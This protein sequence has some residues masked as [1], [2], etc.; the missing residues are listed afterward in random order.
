[1]F[2]VLVVLWKGSLPPPAP[3]LMGK[4]M[5]RIL[6]P[7]LKVDLSSLRLLSHPRGEVLLQTKAVF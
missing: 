4:T 3:V 1:M 2:G 6:H 7:E 5:F